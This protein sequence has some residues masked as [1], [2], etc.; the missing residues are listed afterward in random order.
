M[1]VSRRKL[2]G[3]WHHIGVQLQTD[4][5]FTVLTDDAGYLHMG[6]EAYIGSRHQF[7]RL[8]EAARVALEGLRIEGSDEVADQFHTTVMG[9]GGVTVLLRR[10]QTM[11]NLVHR[12]GEVDEDELKL[13]LET[14]RDLPTVFAEST[15]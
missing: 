5:N 9:L 12:V 13:I 11:K 7:D 10:S 15:R 2:E 4:L 1:P 14:I 8:A 3:L 6:R